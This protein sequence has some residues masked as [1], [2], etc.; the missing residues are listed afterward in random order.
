[1]IK[2][3]QFNFLKDQNGLLRNSETW[4]AAITPGRAELEESRRE[5]TGAEEG[6]CADDFGEGFVAAV[7][8]GDQVPLV[9]GPGHQETGSENN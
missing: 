9:P 7:P 4:R 2:Y 6:H 3:I 5:E 1:M 8:V